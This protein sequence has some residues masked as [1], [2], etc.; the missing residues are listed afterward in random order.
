MH[1]GKTRE[2]WNHTASVLC[3]LANV[4]RDP[5]KRPKAFQPAD[6]HPYG[7]PRQKQGVPLTRK[8]IGLLKKIF[9][10]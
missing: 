8:N 9:V 7:G 6:F 2:A 1:K 5:K 4:N 10:K 3:L